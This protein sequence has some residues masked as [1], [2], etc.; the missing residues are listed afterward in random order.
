MTVA[1]G[2]DVGGT[3]TDFLLWRDGA[4][5]RVAAHRQLLRAL[6]CGWLHLRSPVLPRRLATPRL[7]HGCSLRLQAVRPRAGDG[8]GTFLCSV[9]PRVLAGALGRAAGGT[10][11]L[12]GCG[13]PGPCGLG[14]TFQ[15][16]DRP[17]AHGPPRGRGRGAVGVG[18]ARRGPNRRGAV[19]PE[20]RAET[21][22]GL[23]RSC[24]RRQGV[25]CQGTGP[26]G[27]CRGRVRHC[28]RDRCQG[29]AGQGAC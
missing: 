26:P 22:G 2:V 21:S 12:H 13:R 24:A 25:P 1:L 11:R 18:G 15:R 27:R 3:F 20:H 5:S 10:G 6:L 14:T 29:E 4:R 28:R 7:F 23:C 16:R 8:A 17:P 19:R 9:Q